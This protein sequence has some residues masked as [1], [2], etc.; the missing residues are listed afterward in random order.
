MARIFLA[1]LVSVF[2]LACGTP[3]RGTEESAYVEML[4]L[5]PDSPELNGIVWINDYAKFTLV[6]GAPIPGSD[7]NEEELHRFLEGLA[8][9][10]AWGMAPPV[11]GYRPYLKS[12][13][14]LAL[15]LRNADQS[16]LVIGP[17]GTLSVVRGH[18]DPE[19]TETALMACS[20]CLQRH[21][22]DHRGIPFYSW[23]EKNKSTAEATEPTSAFANYVQGR[24]ISIQQARVFDTGSVDVMEAVID[25]SLGERRSLADKDEFRLL[26]QAM[27]QL[28]T[29]TIV[30]S[31]IPTPSYEQALSDC[32]E[33]LG[34]GQH[35]LSIEVCRQSLSEHL[36]LVP[37]LRPFRAFAMGAG[38]DDRGPY[39]TLVLI[40]DDEG[41]AEENVR[42]LHRRLESGNVHLWSEFV[43]DSNH[44][45]V[46]A[47]GRILSARIRGQIPPG[48]KWIELFEASFTPI[49]PLLIHE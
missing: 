34:S 5:I 43:T 46:S 32:A 11:I 25:T 44:I 42:L 20:S 29:Y 16:I 3:Q 26:S 30:L 17:M 39:L 13:E 22:M 10:P 18:F 27:T 15:D 21:R 14:N 28:D 2:L 47:R 24:Q 23:D 7:T 40:H 37:T 1:I 48:D 8:V 4:G 36:E 19:A 9:L 6:I 35:P 38:A 45:E 49:A 12:I 41:M 33:D 31:D